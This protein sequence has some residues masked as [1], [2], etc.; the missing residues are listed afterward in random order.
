MTAKQFWSLVDDF[1]KP[2]VLPPPAPPPV[3]PRDRTSLTDRLLAALLPETTASG[4]RRVPPPPAPPPAPADGV[5]CSAEQAERQLGRELV[6]VGLLSSDD[7][8]AALRRD[9]E[10]D[11]LRVQACGCSVEAL[12]MP[13]ASCL[14]LLLF[15]HALP[16]ILG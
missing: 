11:E 14:A 12:Y 3:M 1:L 9:P 15:S 6:S 4:T 7:P 13:I 10:G 5:W 16:H 8:V 2:P